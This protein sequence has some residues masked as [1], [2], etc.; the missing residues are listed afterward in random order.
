M[1]S[2]LRNGQVIARPYVKIAVH[3]IKEICACRLAHTKSKPTMLDYH[4]RT[5]NFIIII[6]VIK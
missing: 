2:P 1:K 5:I 3:A 4:I 6:I